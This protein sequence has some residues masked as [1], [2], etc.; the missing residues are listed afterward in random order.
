MFYLKGKL[1]VIEGLDGCG[2]STQLDLLQSKFGDKARFISFPN[3]ESASG[4]IVKDYLS[5]KFPEEDMMTGCFTASSIYAV[6]RY[7]SYKEYWESDYKSG[8]NIVAARYTTSNAIYQMAK[9]EKDKWDEYLDWLW[10]FEYKKFA[11]PKPDMV[12]F[13]DMPIE[14][15][16]KLLSKRYD[17]DESKKDIHEKNIDFLVRCR[18]TALYTAKYDNWQIISCAEGENVRSVEDINNEL[19]AIIESVIL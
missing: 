17:G 9:L 12:I 14:I 10:D 15:S 19:C 11:I 5:G 16:Q 1:I 3:Y 7:T 8:R 18:E 6:D 4:S 2:K 13:L